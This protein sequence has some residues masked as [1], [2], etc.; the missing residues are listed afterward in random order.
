MPLNLEKIRNFVSFYTDKG[1]GELQTYQNAANAQAMPLLTLTRKATYEFG[2][3]QDGSPLATPEA[4]NDYI[5]IGFFRKGLD[6]MW[7]NV[8]VLT[9]DDSAAATF[10]IGLMD[11]EGNF[12]LKATVG[13][14]VDYVGVVTIPAPA[15]EILD[16]AQW[17]VAK[18]TNATPPAS[19]KATFYVPAIALA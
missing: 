9:D 2:V 18:I 1:Y 15:E 5:G 14:A 3:D 10:E 11:A 7:H 4:Q 13:A 8:E 17:V 6:I 16:E 19:G 12:T